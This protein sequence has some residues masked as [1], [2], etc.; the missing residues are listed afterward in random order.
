VLI[1]Y[2]DRVTIGVSSQVGC[3]MGCGFC[4]TGQMGMLGNLSAGDIAARSASSYLMTGT[5]NT[6]MIASP[7]YIWTVPPQDSIASATAEK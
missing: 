3:G 1:G 2:P 6:A 4:A 7:M 5:P